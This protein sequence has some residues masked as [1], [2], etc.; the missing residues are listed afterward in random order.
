MKTDTRTRIQI[1]DEIE[2]LETS[3]GKWTP[4]Y[5]WTAPEGHIVRC[6]Q[7]GYNKNGKSCWR[8]YSSEEEAREN[9]GCN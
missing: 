6:P 9:L 1:S 5:L 7:R 4:Y 2:I 3:P 8:T